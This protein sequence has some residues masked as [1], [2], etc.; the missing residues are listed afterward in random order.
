MDKVLSTHAVSISE[1][2]KSPSKLLKQANGEAVAI[3]NHNKPE[4]YFVPS[5]FYEELIQIADDYYLG[6]EVVAR[7][8]DGD[9]PVAVNL[10]EL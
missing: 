4:G 7:S 1:F 5:A 3:L 2:K 9:T 8:D 10:N 6:L